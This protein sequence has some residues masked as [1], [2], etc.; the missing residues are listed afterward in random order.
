MFATWNSCLAVI[1]ADRQAAKFFPP[2]ATIMNELQLNDRFSGLER[3]I[4]QISNSVSSCA[5]AYEVTANRREIAL[6]EHQ[7]LEIVKRIK[8]LEKPCQ[9]LAANP[10]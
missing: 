2:V 8:K 3:K 5:L 4:T 10:S 9:K 1:E 7:L 6:F